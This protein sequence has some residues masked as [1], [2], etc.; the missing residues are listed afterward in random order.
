[1]PDVFNITALPQDEILGLNA[2]VD[3]IVFVFD[4]LKIFTRQFRIQKLTIRRARRSFAGFRVRV[5]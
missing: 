4:H 5:T 1:M 2:I 3:E